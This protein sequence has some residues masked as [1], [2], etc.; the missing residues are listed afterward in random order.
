MRRGAEGEGGEVEEKRSSQGWWLPG[1]FQ[2]LQSGCQH[3]AHQAGANGNPW[4]GFK[5]LA[6]NS[7]C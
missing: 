6:S 7:E 3:C 1:I 2:A 4:P 5:P